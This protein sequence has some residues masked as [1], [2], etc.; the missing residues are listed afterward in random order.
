MKELEDKIMDR[1][2]GYES[3]L[4]EGDFAKFKSLLDRT[5]GAAPEHNAAYLA[6]LLPAAVAAGLAL[7]FILR[8]APGLDTVQV[9]DNRT[10]TAQAPEPITVDSSFDAVAAGTKPSSVQK[11][12]HHYGRTANGEAAQDC[13]ETV[14]MAEEQ[15]AEAVSLEVESS[16]N[17]AVSSSL[18][19]NDSGSSAFIPTG[20]KIEKKP[21]NIKVGAA[22][23][24]VIG[25]SG[26]IALA[27]LLQPAHTTS[28]VGTSDINGPRNNAPGKKTSTHRMPLRAGLSLRIPVNGRWSLTTGVDYSWYSSKISSKQQ[29]AHYIGIPVRADYSITR[30]SWLD[31]YVGAGVSTD[32][33]VAAF[34]DGCR[35][36]KDG[37]GF[38]LTGVGGVLFSISGNSGLFLEPAFSW[39]IPSGSRVLDTY[40]SEHPCMLSVSTGLRVSLPSGK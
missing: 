10:L 9:I 31:V 6:W 19:N 13:S 7:F 14:I 38:S 24:G 18:T 17:D 23:A 37:I 22:T 29:N 40:K 26:A 11:A 16:G 34:N 39:N 5:S 36:A 27:G 32:F 20:T 30:N 12:Q 35:T 25:G 3:R 33:C 2:E 21:V 1:L 15:P 28:P 8:P 4:P